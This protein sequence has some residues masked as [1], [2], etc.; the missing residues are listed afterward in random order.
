MT[1]VQ[2]LIDEQIHIRLARLDFWE[3]CL[4]MDGDFFSKRPFAQ[5]IAKAFQLL[6]DEYDKGNAINVSV[7]MPPRASK[8]YITSLFSCWWLGKH[9]EK[10]VMRNSC[11]ARLYE[12]FSYDCRS[13]IR[14]EKYRAVFPSVTMAEDK[15]SL[16]G[17]NLSTAKQVSYFG[18]GVGGSIIGFGCNL[19]ISDDLYSGMEQAL[20]E[21]YN[22]KVFMWKQ[23][24]SDSRKEKGTPEIY[25]GTRWSKNDIIGK[26]IEEGMIDIQITIPALIDGK[27]FCEDVK[28]TEEYLKVKEDTDE[29][30]F[31]AEYQQNPIEVKGLLF[32]KS[33]LKFFK[34]EQLKSL[35][36]EYKYMAVDPA[37]L[38]DDTSAPL[39]E[40]YGNG[41]YVTD[42][43]YN[44][45]GTDETI[46]QLVDMI[47]K[48]KLNYVEIE[49]V[50]AWKLFGTQVRN[51]VAE[52]YED[53]E[54]RIIKNNTNKEV[55][56]QQFSA[57]IKNHFYF[58]HEDYWT[59]D[60]QKAMKVL[61]AYLREGKSKRD[62]FPDSLAIASKHFKST[63]PNLF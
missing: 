12:K 63:F 41:I 15:Q 48:N 20:S 9:P 1:D 42:T 49:G 7:S 43:I 57:F 60:Y 45:N 35:Q 22:E 34:P 58:L 54:V 37:D 30:I 8:S 51:E 61:T 17:W 5:K 21:V 62:D 46:P 3:Y 36:S 47:V 28:T 32:P 52:K 19:S 14:S 31:E 53:C 27:S 13:I 16:N 6:N 56:I 50:S 39:C 10:S 38:S 44:N 26:A 25:I 33:Q 40:I 4:W 24:A 23:S 29:A 18:A 11:T 55:R 59:P 2:S